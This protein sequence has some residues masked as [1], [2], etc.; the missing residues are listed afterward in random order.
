[1]FTI[2]HIDKHNTEHLIEA[3]NVWYQ[4][5]AEE[6][7]DTDKPMIWELRYTT[8]PLV[9]GG[10]LTRTIDFGMVYVMNSNGK[11]VASYN[12]GDTDL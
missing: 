4:D 5:N 11:T 1:M 6:V 8:G 3:E 10:R 2:K 7:V 12:L 9:H